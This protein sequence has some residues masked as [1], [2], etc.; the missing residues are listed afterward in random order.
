[1]G[2]LLRLQLRGN[3]YICTR[4]DKHIRIIGM[5]SRIN[6]I[7]TSIFLAKKETKNKWKAL[8]ISYLIY[9]AL[10]VPIEWFGYNVLKIKLASSFN[11]L[12]NLPL[13]HGTP[14][15]KAYYLTAGGLYLLILILLGEIK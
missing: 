5:D 14:I 4:K 2:G 15:L 11:G 10:I 3:K 1:V 9:L 6:A 12:F 7:A 8:G 13:M